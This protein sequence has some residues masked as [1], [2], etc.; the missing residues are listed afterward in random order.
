MKRELK[1]AILIPCRDGELT[2]RVTIESLLNQTVKTF[3]AVA[4]DASVDDTPKILK[5]QSETGR[6][7]SVR[8]PRREPRNYAKVPVL[9]NM[10]LGVLSP[11]D[12]YMIS[13]DDCIYR[14]NTLVN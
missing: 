11:A 3:I 13:G 5:E 12:F 6:V 9:L 4:D 7:H 8:Y 14:L 2:L 10:L 1:V